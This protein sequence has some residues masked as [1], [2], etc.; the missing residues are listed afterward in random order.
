MLRLMLK[1]NS[2]QFNRKNYLQIHGTAMGTKM[3]IA[4]ANIFM[5]D[6]ETQILSKSVI[7]PMIWK[8]YIDN[9]FFVVGCQQTGYRQ[10]HH[11]SKLTPP[12]HQINFTAEISNTEATF[13]DTLS[14][15]SHSGYKNTLQSDWNLSVCSFFL[16]PPTRC[17]KRICEGQSP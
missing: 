12:Y 6:L 5:A 2:F 8:Q 14:T 7:K 15:S 4:F 16:Q 11:T 13:L 9:I 10:V 1:R 17:Q 3:A